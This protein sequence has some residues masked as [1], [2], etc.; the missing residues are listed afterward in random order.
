MEE[1]KRDDKFR[2]LYVY[3]RVKKQWNSA[4]YKCAKCDVNKKTVEGMLGHISYCRGFQP[5]IYHAEPEP[6]IIVTK[7]GKPWKPIDFNQI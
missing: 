1:L 5:K 6:D 2:K 7:D 4:G 3:D